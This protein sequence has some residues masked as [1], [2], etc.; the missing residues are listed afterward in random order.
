MPSSDP[1]DFL[2]SLAAFAEGAAARGLPQK[3]SIEDYLTRLADFAELASFRLLAANN[4]IITEAAAPASKKQ[5]E[6]DKGGKLAYYSFPVPS[7]AHKQAHLEIRQRRDCVMP[8]SFFR[9]ACLFMAPLLSAKANENGFGQ[10]TG[11]SEAM[12]QTLRQIAIVA[13]SHSTVLIQGESGTGKELAAR[14]IHR[15]G[16]RP[17]GPFISLNC[18]ALPEN[19]IE[20]ELFG[21]ERGAFTGAEKMR[22]GRFEH[23][24]GGTLFLDEI[25][26]LGPAIQAK[27]LRAL[28]ERAFERLGGMNTIKVDARI[29]AATNRD[30][31]KMVEKGEFRRDL[32]YRLNVFPICMPALRDRPE[33]IL[34]LAARFLRIHAPQARFSGEA[35]SLLQRHSWPGNVRELE[36][37]IERAAL[38]LGGDTILLPEHLPFLQNESRFGAETTV[39]LAKRIADL[40][41]EYIIKALALSMGKI[42]KAAG[43]L[44][45]T[46]RELGLRLK[47]YGISYKT[48]RPLKN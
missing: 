37:I 15:A 2:L 10:L 14:A 34:P 6:E 21:H 1:F 25:G 13:P 29:I 41:Q 17:D 23:A 42:N 32:F 44:G 20:S 9:L 26:E 22:I 46:E 45:L 4:K 3:K 40:E 12:R 43:R 7:E 16:P 48:Y 8:E 5:A 19:L 39:N 30:L 31:I 24:N 35:A 47:K 33:D 18:A 28:Q 38:L 11:Q 27:L 36:N